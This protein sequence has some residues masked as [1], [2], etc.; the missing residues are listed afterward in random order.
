MDAVA[1]LSV[2]LL[3]MGFQFLLLGAAVSLFGMGMA[4]EGGRSLWHAWA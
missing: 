4:L 3:V 1:L 2:T